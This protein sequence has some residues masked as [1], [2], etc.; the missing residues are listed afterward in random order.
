MLFWIN[1][2][3]FC[4]T[5]IVPIHSVPNTIILTIDIS[6]ILDSELLEGRH[7][8]LLST[9]PLTPHRHTL[10]KQW[11]DDK[12][13]YWYNYAVYWKSLYIIWYLVLFQSLY[14]IYQKVFNN[15]KSYI[16]LSRTNNK[17]KSIALKHV[18]SL[19]FC[20]CREN[21]TRR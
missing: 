2:G 10:S 3:I 12:T 6:P 7:C 20:I 14:S 21:G 9:I 18:S 8:Y 4:L 19:M 1:K 13:P 5:I 16:I 17:S 11:S 15:C